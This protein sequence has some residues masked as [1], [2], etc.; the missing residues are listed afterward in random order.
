MIDLA[1][2]VEDRR[3][4]ASEIQMPNVPPE[5]PENLQLHLDAKQIS[6]LGLAAIAEVGEE[7]TIQAKGSVVALEGG[8]G[9][10]MTI[11]LKQMGFGDQPDNHEPANGQGASKGKVRSVMSYYT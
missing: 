1:R 4:E 7:V 8:D 3:E 6:D 5:Y 11:Q 9:R 10:T 2:P